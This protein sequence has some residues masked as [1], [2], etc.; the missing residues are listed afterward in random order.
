MSRENVKTISRGH[1]GKKRALKSGGKNLK[2]ATPWLDKDWYCNMLGIVILPQF[3]LWFIFSNNF[4]LY[5]VKLALLFN[6]F[7]LD[8]FI[9]NFTML[10]FCFLS[11]KSA[12][13][14]PIIGR[15]QTRRT[16]GIFI[17]NTAYFIVIQRSISSY[18]I[19]SQWNIPYPVWKCL[20]YGS[21][22]APKCC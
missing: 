20:W 11:R 14:V 13:Y 1:L 7:Y 5:F 15:L 16:W 4:Y 12:V 10:S 3:I 21:L 2:V 22:Q 18:F 17:R 8:Y 6:F 19:E 9:F